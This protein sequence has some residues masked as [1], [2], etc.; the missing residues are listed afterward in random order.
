MN[1]KTSISN[2]FNKLH[3]RIHYITNINF[4]LN[5]VLK[6]Y[7]ILHWKLQ[8]LKVFQFYTRKL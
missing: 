5:K 4:W 6:N 1:K 2:I 3:A 8:I 7:K